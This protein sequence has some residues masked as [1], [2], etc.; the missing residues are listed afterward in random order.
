MIAELIRKCYDGQ[1]VPYEKTELLRLFG[2]EPVDLGMK[3]PD[4]DDPLISEK[5]RK[6]YTEAIS[7]IERRIPTHI[8]E[9][10]DE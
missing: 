10:R 2:A 8:T 5:Y 3:V 6:F 7:D 1:S 4:K 9:K